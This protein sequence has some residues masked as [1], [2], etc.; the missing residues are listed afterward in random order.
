MTIQSR[1]VVYQQYIIIIGL[2]AA[3]V[4]RPYIQAFS[5]LC[6]LTGMLNHAFLRK[7]KLG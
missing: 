1:H 2:K 7:L 3:R 4:Y 5:T 6:S